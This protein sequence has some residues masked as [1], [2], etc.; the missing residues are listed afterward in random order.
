MSTHNHNF[1]GYG[2]YLVYFDNPH[3]FEIVTCDETYIYRLNSLERRI[4]LVAAHEGQ[5]VRPPGT[6][7][8]EF[9]DRSLSVPLDV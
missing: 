9:P 1:R 3:G 4:E 6:P 5:K 2:P 8:Y 7:A